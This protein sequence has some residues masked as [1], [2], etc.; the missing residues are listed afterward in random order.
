MNAEIIVKKM[1]KEI[2]NEYEKEKMIQNGGF[3]QRTTVSEFLG[4][5]KNV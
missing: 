5:L 4:G 1:F 3:V 2:V